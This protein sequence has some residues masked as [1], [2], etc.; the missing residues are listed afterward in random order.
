MMPQEPVP[1]DPANDLIVFA[2]TPAKLVTA[3]LQGP[4]GEL[5]AWTLRTPTT[6]LTVLVGAKTA[7]AWAAQVT[8]EAAGMSE[9]GLVTGGVAMPNGNGAH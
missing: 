4:G 5:M 9:S 6:T 7:K 3:K 2:E 1:V 8:R